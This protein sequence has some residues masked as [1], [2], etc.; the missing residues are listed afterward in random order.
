MKRFRF[1]LE[2]ILDLRRRAE[3][4]Q[5]RTL[6]AALREEDARRRALQD[7]E[8]RLERC[9]KQVVSAG[10]GASCPAGLLNNLGMAVRAAAADAA[11]AADQH[12]DAEQ[13]LEDEHRLF[14][15]T[16]KERRV[17]EMLREK[18]R[19]SWEQEAAREEQW[20][21]DEISHH[22]RAAGGEE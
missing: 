10:D 16:K 22:R 1:R 9:G 20:S 4:E 5:A 14:L 21:I 8:A 2:R 3:E 6:G 7:A 19:M 11:R 17:V 18:R 12:R 13:R 15:E